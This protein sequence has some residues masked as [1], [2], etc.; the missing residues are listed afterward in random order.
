MLPCSLY[1]LLA[2]HCFSGPFA[3]ARIALRALSPNRQT[4]S[5]AYTSVTIYIPQSR[6][7][8]N[9]LS[10][11]LASD[12]IIAVNNLIYSAKLVF[13]EFV[14]LYMSFDLRFFQNLS[15]RIFT[16]AVNIR[17]GNPYRFVIR[18]IN[19]NY[20]RHISSFFNK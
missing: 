5:V 8:L 19:T 9:N 20:T 17:Q 7:I 13:T 1:T 15:R 16:Y 11:K 18:N 10:A 12:N 4:L 2:R 14:G 6:D 3:G